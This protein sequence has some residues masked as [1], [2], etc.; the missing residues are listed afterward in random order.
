MQDRPAVTSSTN[1]PPPLDDSAVEG[2]LRFHERINRVSLVIATILLVSVMAL[3]LGVVPIPQRRLLRPLWV[4]GVTGLLA[5]EAWRHLGHGQQSGRL[6][7]TRFT[8][9]ACMGAVAIGEALHHN[10]PSLDPLAERP[11]G[12]AATV[13]A[14]A[15]VCDLREFSYRSRYAS[16]ARAGI[17]VGAIG[18]ALMGA[19]LLG[20]P[21]MPFAL[22]WRLFVGSA[23]LIA[24]AGGIYLRVRSAV[25]SSP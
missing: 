5:L 24:I 18:T 3:Y 12:I 10:W 22:W 7:W 8:L 19:S 2:L 9:A 1:V 13:L 16:L 15:L 11:L 14:I 20:E 6:R 25:S 21:M 4:F 17:I 23:I